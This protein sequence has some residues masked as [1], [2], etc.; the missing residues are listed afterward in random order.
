VKRPKVGETYITTS[1]IRGASRVEHRLVGGVE[2][3]IVPL[4][5]DSTI[6]AETPVRVLR[7]IGTQGRRIAHVETV[8]APFREVQVHWDN[9]A[10]MGA[11]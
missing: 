9:L 1:D 3:K 7:V 8:A 6:L 5:G 10:P 4:Y 11:Y 2:M